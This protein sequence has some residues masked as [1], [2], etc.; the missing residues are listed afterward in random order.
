MTLALRLI[1]ILTAVFFLLFIINL[2]RK[3]RLSEKDSL[4]WILASIGMLFVSSAPGLTDA[5]A[6][7]LGMTY[8]AMIYVYTAIIFM[9]FIICYHSTRLSDITE[10]TK[11]QAQRIALLEMRLKK[12]GLIDKVKGGTNEDSDS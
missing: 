9:L 2:V 4:L 3:R 1:T 10:K 12:A 7:F 11:E 6:A 8:S 5:I